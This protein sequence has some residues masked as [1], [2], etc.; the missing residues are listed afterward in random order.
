MAHYNSKM[1]VHLF[2]GLG[3]DR[4]A[5]SYRLCDLTLGSKLNLDWQR[6]DFLFM[7]T[8]LSRC[9]QRHLAVL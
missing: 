5:R 4:R 6:S 1:A 8:G 2:G 3:G 9:G 7:E